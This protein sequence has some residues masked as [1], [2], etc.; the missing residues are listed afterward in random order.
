MPDD[1][2]DAH[3]EEARRARI[4]DLL[5]EIALQVDGSPTVVLGWAIVVEWS[6]ADGDRWLTYLATDARG[7]AAP[8]WQAQGY[9][10]NALNDWPNRDEEEG[11]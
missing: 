7:D 2:V 5:H 11:D 3:G 6:A 8:T 9:L 4:H 1:D 10:H